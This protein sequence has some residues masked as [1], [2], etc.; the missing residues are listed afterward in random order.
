[1]LTNTFCHMPRVSSAKEMALW[2]KGVL[3][4]DDYRKEVPKSVHID[5]SEIH[6]KKKN[7]NYFA[8]G[9]K[10]DQ[11][12][13]LFPD[14]QDSVAY[15]DIE[16][17]GLNKSYDEITTIAL[18]DGHQIRTYVNGRNLDQFMRDIKDYR[19]LVTF[20]G[21]TFDM[22][23]IKNFFGIELDHAHIDL[24][25]VLGKLGYKGGLKAIERRVGIDRRD[26]RDVDGFFAVSLWHE[27]KQKKNEQ[28]LETLLAYNC[29]DVVN[30]EE[31]MIL[32]VNLNIKATPFNR[33]I[34]APEK[35][36][37]PFIVDRKLVDRYG[38]F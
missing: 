29:T 34:G 1:M 4:W 26:L 28:A 9:L 12:W 37:I 31:L 32:A 14:F 2:N 30:L 18:Y 15:L 35:F 17:T 24:R 25:Y 11:H 6:L 3:T 38:Y 19:V 16:T 5:D 13:R 7:P 8:N 36:K 23:F 21:K 10:S 27:F 20:N 22:P 33:E